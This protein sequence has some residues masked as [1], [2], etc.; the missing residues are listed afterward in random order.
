MEINLGQF[1][2]EYSSVIP[3]SVRDGKIFKITHSK[4]FKRININAD[5]QKVIPYE[6]IIAFEKNLE[7]AI[8]AESLRLKCRYAPEL[9]S[10]DEIPNIVKM[11]KRDVSAVN[12]FLDNAGYYISEDTLNIKLMHGGISI[13]NDFRD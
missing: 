8:S 7:L 5:F 2:N 9:F 1:L 6:D 12:G 10:V 4:D 11:L 13:L 3:D